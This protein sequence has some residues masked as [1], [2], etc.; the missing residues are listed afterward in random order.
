MLPTAPRRGMLSGSGSRAAEARRR[1]LRRVLLVAAGPRAVRTSGRARYATSRGGRATLYARPRR[2]SGAA[3]TNAPP[4]A[5]MPSPRRSASGGAGTIGRSARPARL[6]SARRVAVRR[7]LPRRGGR[8][9]DSTAVPPQRDPRR[10]W[11]RGAL[12]RWRRTAPCPIVHNRAGHAQR[13]ASDS[14]RLAPRT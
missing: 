3:A 2:R 7:R 11:P 9:D 8:F 13:A 4:S 5:R 10:H 1:R 12:E 14:S 6:K